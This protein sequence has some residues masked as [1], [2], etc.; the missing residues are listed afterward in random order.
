MQ[1]RL[2]HIVYFALSCLCVYACS[3]QEPEAQPPTKADTSS[4]PTDLLARNQMERLNDIG[5]RFL[6]LLDAVKWDQEALFLDAAVASLKA[7]DE[8]ED[9]ASTSFSVDGVPGEA[10][11][12]IDGPLSTVTL[13]R[14]GSLL[15]S[16][17]IHEN[18]ALDVQM[19]HY[20][21]TSEAL[22]E[23]LSISSSTLWKD[24]EMI[25]S[26]EVT[27]QGPGV[28]RVKAQVLDGE[29]FIR[30]TVQDATLQALKLRLTPTMDEA[31]GRALASDLDACLSLGLYY[32][33]FEEQAA[34]IGIGPFHRQTRFDDYWS[35]RWEIRFPDGLTSPVS[36]LT[37]YAELQDVSAALTALRVQL[38][39]L[40][41]HLYP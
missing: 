9:G 32:P 27:P 8:W 6:L 38:S 18:G 21:Y 20:R 10:R 41:P 4:I 24:G 23:G 17:N 13:Y 3:R 34:V 25:A 14:S 31:G 40:L 35:W 11:L 37:S 2:L 26:M 19:Q 33:D 30:G 22:E 16:A 1:G 39:T 15:S 5:S 28:A 36:Q 7:D 12:Q 29:V